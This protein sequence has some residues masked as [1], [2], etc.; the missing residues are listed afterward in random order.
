[1]KEADFSPVLLRQKIQRGNIMFQMLVGHSTKHFE[2]LLCAKQ[3]TIVG[4]AKSFPLD[5]KL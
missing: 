3:C 4:A 5:K 2:Y 1:M